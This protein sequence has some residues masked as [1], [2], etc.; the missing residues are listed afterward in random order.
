MLKHP[1]KRF[2]SREDSSHPQL[3]FAGILQA[4]FCVAAGSTFLCTLTGFL[5]RFW[6]V[7]DL[8]SHFRVQYLAS[9]ILVGI[10][11]VWFRKWGWCLVALI[12]IGLNAGTVLP[13]MFPMSPVVVD[14]TEETIRLVL[15]NVHR[16]NGQYH[17]V[18]DFL[19]DTEPDLVVLEEVDQTWLD[20][21]AELKS[22]LPHSVEAPRDDDFGIAL[23]SRYPL[24]Q[25]KV[26]YLGDASVPSVVVLVPLEKVTL[27]ILGTHPVPPGGNEYSRLRNQQLSAIAE[28]LRSQSDPMILIGD[29]NTTPWNHYFKRLLRESGLND[30]A[31]V[32]GYQP[33]WPSD[34]IFLRI[35]LDH[36]LISSDWKVI[37]RRVGPPVGSDHFPLIVELALR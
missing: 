19:R 27:T 32:F 31:S 33:T 29:L 4:L 11:F 24:E 9:A 37:H 36:C 3:S 10:V 14:A 7:F 35:S 5:G 17:L 16:S 1:S 23:L 15:V 21:L 6:W 25:G 18:K 8:T 34:L 30:S 2:Y 20:N 13:H 22:Q 26:A 28:F 12:A